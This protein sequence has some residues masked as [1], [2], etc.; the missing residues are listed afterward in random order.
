MEDGLTMEIGVPVVRYVVEELRL[1]PGPALTQHQ[2]TVE[3]SVKEMLMRHV[4]VTTTLV[5]VIGNR[6]DTTSQV[7]HMW[8]DAIFHHL[9]HCSIS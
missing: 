3:Q 5:Q 1:D 7:S 8:N 6:L 2:L 4:H 9:H